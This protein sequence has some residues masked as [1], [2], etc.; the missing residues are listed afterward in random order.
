M[1]ILFYIREDYLDNMAG[2]TIQFMKTRQYLEKLGVKIDVSHDPYGDLRAYDLI[3]LFNTIRIGD[4]YRFY[5]NGIKYKK[6]IV[7]TPI[8]W[9]YFYHIPRNEKG[10]MEQ[11]YWN[12]G[13]RQRKEVF[14]GVDYVLPSSEIEMRQI[15]ANFNLIKDYTVVPNGVDCCFKEGDGSKFMQ[16]FSI[17]DY[18]LCVG[19]IC[20]HKNQLTLAKI[21]HQLKVPF[22][23]VGPVNHLGYYYE[24]VQAN[25]NLIYLPKVSHESLA[26]IY[27]GA[28][29][30][31]LVSW[32]EIPGLVNL[33][34][35]LACCH[36]LTTREGSTQEYFKDF[37]T[38][39]DPHNLQEIKEKLESL[40]NREKTTALRDYILRNFLWEDVA[41]GILKVYEGLIKT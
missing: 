40:I 8:Y 17:K 5:R 26:D 11:V 34:A 6:K 36:I 3:H 12:E 27:H 38:Y 39:V 25:S 15:E 16:Q 14:S 19:R 18:V 21:T 9:N 37:A 4:T 28:R 20:K 23:M 30:H 2:D 35:G 31:G 1:R 24:C 41:A 22:V 29:V 33:E 7:L 13:N 10:Q 32:Y